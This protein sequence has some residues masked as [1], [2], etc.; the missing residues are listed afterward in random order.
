MNFDFIKDLDGLKYAY[1]YCNNAE[2]L[3][4]S[5][6][7]LSMISSR[8]SAEM[9]AKLIYLNT[10]S[11]E[12]G[13]LTF[14]NIL[15]DDGVKKYLGSSKILDAFHFIR[16][17]GNIAAHELNPVSSDTAVSVLSRLHYI[18]GEAAKK[19]GL[20]KNYPEFREDIK[21][22]DDVK[23]LENEA[24]GM[25]A[26][27]IYDDLVIANHKLDMLKSDF[28][29][30][31]NPWH[32][33]SNTVELFDRLQFEEKPKN[34]L[35]IKKIQEYYELLGIRAMQC[36]LH[37][38]DDEYS[39]V[40]FMCELKYN[41]DGI[42]YKVTGTRDF[43]FELIYNLQD[44]DGFEI[45]TEYIG[46][47]PWDD[48]EFSKMFYKTIEEDIGETEK[49]NYRLIAYYHGHGQARCHKYID[50]KKIDLLWTDDVEHFDSRGLWY[51]TGV[52]LR[53]DFD[54]GAHP[55]ILA[56]LQD[57]TREYMPED[58]LDYIESCWMNNPGQ[59]VPGVQFVVYTMKYV[60]KFLDEVN[61][62]IKPIA[63]EC[64]ILSYGEWWL[65]EFP[66]GK[67]TW[68]LTDDGLKVIGYTL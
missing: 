32:Y 57:I 63:D 24:T 12:S 58:E 43:L 47:S 21:S 61:A 13:P 65:I 8:K 26:K 45:Y 28:E 4:L 64:Q 34:I 50:G 31:N 3:A 15:N 51:T 6:P 2:E 44:F 39:P 59:L 9:L 54:F 27:K 33:I 22:N 62:V 46:P 23:P 30:L 7:D 53:I 19:M 37:T 56:A 36:E 60:Q 29:E 66:F 41:K 35:T 16:K 25:M 49:F 52:S 38:K 55:D 68:D 17:K 42:L 20:I 5:K 14:A 1:E 11:E 67:A 40:S 48:R 18:V 10:Y